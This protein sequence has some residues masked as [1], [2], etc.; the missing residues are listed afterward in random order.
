MLV[1]SPSPAGY[2]QLVTGL[3]D[4]VVAIIRKTGAADALPELQGAGQ[5]D[6]GDVV[7]DLP[8][9]ETCLGFGRGARR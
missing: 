3:D 4:V 9:Q 7:L 6:Q 8:L 2:L 5:S 1:G